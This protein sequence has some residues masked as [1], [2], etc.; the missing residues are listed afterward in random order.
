MPSGPRSASVPG[1]A[2]RSGRRHQEHRVESRRRNE[3]PVIAVQMFD[4]QLVPGPFEFAGNRTAGRHELGTQCSMRKMQRMALSHAPNTG[5]AYT[6]RSIHPRTSKTH[7]PQR[8]LRTL[9]KD[10][11]KKYCHV[12]SVHWLMIR[13][14]E[15][16]RHSH[17]SRYTVFN[18]NFLF[19]VVAFPKRV[20][21]AIVRVSAP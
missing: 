9:R 4:V 13:C 5:D 20:L 6:K 15:I 21:H 12:R 11:R 14:S 18:F 16:W 19:L 2:G 1:K 8:T 10:K 17:V 3:V 7:S